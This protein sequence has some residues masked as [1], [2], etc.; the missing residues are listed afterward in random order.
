MSSN[1]VSENNGSLFS[2]EVREAGSLESRCHTA[3]LPLKA[4][5]GNPVPRLV[6]GGSRHPS[7]CGCITLISVSLFTQPSPLCLCLLYFC[8]V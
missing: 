8:F 4:P 7:A 5:R 2:Q 1:W 6:Y 3:V